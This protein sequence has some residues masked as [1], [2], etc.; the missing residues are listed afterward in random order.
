MYNPAKDLEEVNEIIMIEKL[1]ALQKTKEKC[2]EYGIEL[3]DYLL[4][5]LINSINECK[6]SYEY[7]NDKE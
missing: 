2:E 1:Q 3:R 7:L 6:E 4:F 5:Q